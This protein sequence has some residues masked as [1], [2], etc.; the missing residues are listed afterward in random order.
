MKMFEPN[1]IKMS[2]FKIENLKDNIPYSVIE[3][4]INDINSKVIIFMNGLNGTRNWMKYYNHSVFDNNF[5]ISF[6]QKGQAENKSKPSKFYKN[7][8]NY[9]IEVVDYI[10]KKSEFKNLDIILIGESW[11]AIAC[12]L[13]A[14]KNPNLIKGF[15]I[16]NMPGKLPSR[17]K[18]VS[19][20]KIFQLSIKT[21]FTTITNINTKSEIIFDE[22][23][24]SNNLLIR[25]SRNTIRKYENN[26]T[27]IAVFFSIS[28]AWKTIIKNNLLVPF[29]YIQSKQDIMFEPKRFSKISEYK[30][31][32]F[33]EKGHHILIL[34]KN[35]KEIFDK[36]DNFINSLHI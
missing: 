26:K 4:I 1:R 20:K 6:D 15:V 12:L 21:L 36:L 11:G 3:P 25:A 31:V 29:I 16:W 34:E 2:Y 13:M 33:L 17:N 7:L 22:R 28:P 27:S 14:K 10:S 30:N 18:E 19:N 8:I 35:S 23:L 24:T 9:N 32:F 5:L